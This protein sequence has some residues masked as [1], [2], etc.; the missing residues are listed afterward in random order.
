MRKT[1]I[2]LGALLLLIGGCSKPDFEMETPINLGVQSTSTAIKSD[3]QK[4]NVV[5]VVFETTVV[6]FKNVVTDDV[7]FGVVT[8]CDVERVCDVVE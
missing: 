4:D 8:K 6:T 7:L 2:V 5:T 1:L 3:N